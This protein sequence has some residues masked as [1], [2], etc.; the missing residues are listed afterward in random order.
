VA[1]LGPVTKALDHLAR[2]QWTAVG[3]PLGRPVPAAAGVLD[4]RRT[5]RHRLRS[6]D[7]KLADDLDLSPVETTPSAGPGTPT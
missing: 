3:A 1:T 2:R 7:A 5:R 4:R 6:H